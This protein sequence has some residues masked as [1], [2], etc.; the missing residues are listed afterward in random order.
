MDNNNK[1]TIL[2]LVYENK[3]VLFGRFSEKLTHDMKINK[4][5]E[6][7]EQLKSLGIFSKDWKYLRDTTWQNFRKRTIVSIFLFKVTSLTN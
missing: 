7:A 1:I 6:I 3:E 2:S 4:W 5:K